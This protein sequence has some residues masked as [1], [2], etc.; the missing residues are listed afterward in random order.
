M[1]S[2]IYFEAVELKDGKK[3]WL[4]LLFNLTEDAFKLAESV[5]FTEGE[6][7]YEA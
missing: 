2:N 4:D 1:K 5:E 7:A 3:E 6:N